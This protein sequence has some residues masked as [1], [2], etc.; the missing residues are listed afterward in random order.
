MAD[1]LSLPE[2]ASPVA[3]RADLVSAPRGERPV[4]AAGTELGAR[5]SPL[6]RYFEALLAAYGPQRWWPGRSRFEVIAGAILTQ[7][8]SWKNVEL[9]VRN[10]RKAGL[11]S[12]EAVRR[13]SVAR[14]ARL[15]RPSGT[16]RQKARTLK[17]FVRFLDHAYRGS[18]SRM[19][20]A[21]TGALRRE[22]LSLRGIGPETADAILLYAGRHPVFVAD[23]Y[24]RRI[25]ERHALLR[26]GAGYEEVRTAFE[27]ALPADHRVLN[28][29]HALIVHVGKNFCRPV[30][31]CPDC[32]LSCFLPPGPRP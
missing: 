29:L 25:L 14:L 21:P 11:L 9:A 6:P 31:N 24:A 13:T 26:D 22:L 15:I 27:S 28:E 18:L 7:N 4:R 19:L 17:T 30:P 3:P 8:T 10:L 12:P 16:F 32:A 2:W 20:R 1:F 23:A 5:P